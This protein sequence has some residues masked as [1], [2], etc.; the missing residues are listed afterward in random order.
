VA[1]TTKANGRNAGQK[2][3][4]V[5]Y[6]VGGGES[7]HLYAGSFKTKQEALA[8]KRQYLPATQQGKVSS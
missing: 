1:R 4:R 6:R 7:D 8:R 2:R 5:V 3:Y